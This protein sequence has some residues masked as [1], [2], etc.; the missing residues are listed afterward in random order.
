MFSLGLGFLIVGW[1]VGCILKNLGGT[2]KHSIGVKRYSLKSISRSS[3]SLGLCYLMQF[4][5]K[6]PVAPK[7]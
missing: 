2:V 5:G 6:I 7:E 4:A 3:R 1:L